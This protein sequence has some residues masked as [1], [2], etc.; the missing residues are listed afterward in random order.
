MG[1]GSVENMPE[2]KR[3]MNLLGHETEVTDLDIVEKKNERMAEYT[4]EDGSVIRFIAYP[5][6]VIRLDGQYNPDG[7]PIY[8][9]LNQPVTTVVSSP[10]HLKRKQ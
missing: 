9:V 10:E 6:A 2:K 4:L 7:T 1:R 5:T 3:K 8:L